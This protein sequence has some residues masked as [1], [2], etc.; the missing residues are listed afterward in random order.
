MNTDT[1]GII[2]VGI[3]EDKTKVME[4]KG[5]ELNDKEKQ[6]FLYFLHDDIIK[7]VYP[8]EE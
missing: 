6:D 1:G 4:N 3:K 8:K 2:Y 5:I 7:G